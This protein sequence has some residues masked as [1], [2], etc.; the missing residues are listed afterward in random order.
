MLDTKLL[1]L[2]PGGSGKDTAGQWFAENTPLRFCGSSSL[3][4][5]RHM[6]AE[7][8]IEFTQEFYA[9]RHQNR[10]YWKD[11]GDKLR[12]HDPL[13][14]T[15]EMLKIS[16]IVCGLR[17]TTE[18]VD[19]LR[20]GLITHVLFLN[21]VSAEDPTFKM[22]KP[23]ISSLCSELKLTAKYLFNYKDERF[24]QSLKHTCQKWGIPLVQ[25]QNSSSV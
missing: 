5:G 1:I 2:G 15:K 12:A 20:S 23:A 22:G 19:T 16:D 6:A 25:H 8:G 9:T 21:H 17:G 18:I 13:F 10:V 14:F 11:Y 24:F 4:I 3:I 7:Q